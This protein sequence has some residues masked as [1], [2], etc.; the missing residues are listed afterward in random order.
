MPTPASRGD[1]RRPT[2]LQPQGQTPFWRSPEFLR[3]AAIA[4]VALGGAAAFLFSQGAVTPKSV[5]TPADPAQAPLPA[6]VS[7]TPEQRAER[8]AFLS[9]AF[10]GALRDQ[11]DGEPLQDTTGSRK[12][13]QQIAN[14]DADEFRSRTTRNLDYAA[15]TTDPEAWRGQFVRLYGILG[16]VWAEKLDQPVAGRE[17][18]WRAQLLTGDNFSEPNLLEFIDRPLPEMSLRD[19]RLRAVEVEGVF[20]R[21]GSFESVYQNGKDQTV[22]A[23]WTLPWVFVRN[24]RLIDEG[25]DDR[26]TFLNDYPKVIL[27]VLALVIFGG[28]LLFSW[29]QGRRRVQRRPKPPSDIRTMFEQKLREKGLPPAPPSPPQT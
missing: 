26:H 3:F 18:T 7:L 1:V 9:A 19:Q 2:F 20:Y 4:L 28:R 14:F 25:T 6:T 13:L 24:L 16:E 22:E 27:A 29:I 23:T 12:L 10:E 17:A 21:S 11:A 8:D 15:A 5:P